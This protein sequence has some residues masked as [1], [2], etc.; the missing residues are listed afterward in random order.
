M[1]NIAG[2]TNFLI[3]DNTW[4]D[5]KQDFT[6]AL[7]AKQGAGTPGIGQARTY[8]NYGDNAGTNPY[9]Y[10]GSPNNSNDLMIEIFDGV[11]FT[12]STHNTPVA[13]ESKYVGIIYN[14]TTHVLSYYYNGALI[15]TLSVNFSTY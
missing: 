7:F 13:G 8:Y 4:L 10:F 14:A 3:R 12:D 15:G 2:S 1:I 11:T 5:P 9:I 6:I